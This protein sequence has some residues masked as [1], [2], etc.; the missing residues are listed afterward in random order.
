MD[1]KLDGAGL[2]TVIAQDRH[3]GEIRMV[4]HADAEALRA[5]L[6]TG[7]AHFHS[8]SRGK[9]WKKGE[10]SGNTMAVAEVWADCD[11]DAFLYFVDPAGPTCHTGAATCFFHRADGGAEG[12]AS[13]TLM[14]LWSTL[15][16]RRSS[17][18]ERSYT[19][20]LLDGGSEAIGA[21]VREEAEELSRALADET[22]ARVVAEA[23]DVLYHLM[24]G[25]LHRGLAFRDVEA[26]LSRRSSSS[27][28][29]EK[30]TR[31]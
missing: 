17:T 21:K 1:L 18:G 24:V 15:E 26:E 4:A 8:R 10:E 23:A 16:A 27:G 9:L 30:A 29:A 22:D 25:L 12:R 28:H 5:T 3:T 14:R 11:R 13:P 20:S 31:K 7:F 19:R 6:E 2:V